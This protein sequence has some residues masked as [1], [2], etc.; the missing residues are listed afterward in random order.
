MTA[1]A[2]HITMQF[3]PK[4][5]D[6]LDVINNNRRSIFFLSTSELSPDNTLSLQPV[7]RDI[8]GGRYSK[9][10]DTGRLRAEVQN[11]TLTYTIFDRDKVPLSY[12][13]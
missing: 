13:F 12:T 3:S 1:Q 9:K 6:F 10:F 11:R 5:V 4:N 8:G 2:T 7:K